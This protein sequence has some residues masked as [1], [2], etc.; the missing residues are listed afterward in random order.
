MI[1]LLAFLFGCRHKRYSWPITDAR[2][3]TYVVCWDCSQPVPYKLGEGKVS[4]R[5]A[6]YIRRTVASS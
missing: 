2:R 6:S 1:R 3:Q 4:T 5:K